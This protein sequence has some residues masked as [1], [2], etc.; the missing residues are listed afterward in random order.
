MTFDDQ[1]T[2]AT[3]ASPFFIPG[4]DMIKTDKIT[5]TRFRAE[6]LAAV[7]AFLAERSVLEVE[8]PLL[9]RGASHDFHIDVFQVPGA[10]PE[11][12]SARYLQS[13][14]E[15]HMKR[16]LAKGYPDIY[17]ICKAFRLEESGRLHNPE[18]TM[19]EWYRLGYR[20]RQMMEETVTLCAVVAGPREVNYF[21]Y[22]NVFER[23]TGMMPIKTK[24]ETLLTHPVFS[25]R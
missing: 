7:R 25:N 3:L 6:K 14:P 1:Q 2:K 17:Q 21:S 19:I 18:F 15:P 4:M 13:S 8:T 5:A 16:L 22:E 23:V 9:S 10:G 24:R 20:L 11:A 12:G